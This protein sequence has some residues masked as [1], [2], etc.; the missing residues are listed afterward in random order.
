MLRLIQFSTAALLAARDAIARDG[1]KAEDLAEALTRL[2]SGRPLARTAD[3]LI[4]QFRPLFVLLGSE[5][6]PR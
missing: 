5:V 1:I 4:D 3:A 6:P 2:F